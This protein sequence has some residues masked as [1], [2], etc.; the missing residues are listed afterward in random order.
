MSVELEKV[1]SFFAL[2]ETEIS[3]AALLLTEFKDFT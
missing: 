2:S 3:T 1:D